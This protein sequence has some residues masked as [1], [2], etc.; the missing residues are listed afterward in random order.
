MPGSWKIGT[1]WFFSRETVSV[2][3]ATGIL[4]KDEN[5]RMCRNVR[6]EK[7]GFQICF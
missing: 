2:N 1:H 6:F 5:E 7:W 4:E 3:C